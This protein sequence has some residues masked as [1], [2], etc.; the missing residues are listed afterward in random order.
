M[1]KNYMTT[2]GVKVWIG[3]EY[4]NYALYELITPEVRTGVGY[5]LLLNSSLTGNG[6]FNVLYIYLSH[7]PTLYCG[8]KLLLCR[9]SCT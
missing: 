9:I 6:P 7:L 5:N 1:L 8:R 3:T 2:P 4:T